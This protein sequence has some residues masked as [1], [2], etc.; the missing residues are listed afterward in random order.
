MKLERELRVALSTAML[1]AEV[2]EKIYQTD[3]AV[4]WKSENDPVTK[5][6]KEANALIV[7]ALRYAFPRDSICAE[8]SSATE[9]RAA[10]QHG[11]RT[12]FVDPLDGT[13]EFIKKNGEF[14]VMIGLAIEG[15]PVVGAI[16]EP[17]SHRVFCGIV[18]EQAWELF[19]EG[20]RVLTPSGETNP[21]H[22]RLLVSRSRVSETTEALIKRLG[23]PT[24]IPCGSTG[25]K[26]ARVA[27]GEADAYIHTDGNMMLWDG[28]APEAIARAAGLTVTNTRGEAL[29]YHGTSLELDQGIIVASDTLATK[30]RAAL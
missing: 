10:A 22:T 9:A 15:K 20:P 5:A 12:W 4:D 23:I 21:T 3:F 6:D 2:I 25:V 11:G 27:C 26:I 30:L 14:C 13:R 19:D 8:E 28:C 29:S 1:A 7:D 16:V 17:S 24:R 18:G